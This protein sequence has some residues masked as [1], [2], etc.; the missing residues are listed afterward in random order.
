MAQSRLRSPLCPRPLPGPTPGGDTVG[1]VAVP[2]GCPI[3]PPPISPFFGQ[4]GATGLQG[5]PPWWHRV[6]GTVP[7]SG[8]KRWRGLKGP[9]CAAGSAAGTGM[10][11]GTEALPPTICHLPFIPSFL[12]LPASFCPVPPVPP[13]LPRSRPRR[14]GGGTAGDREGG[15][16]EGRT[17]RQVKG[18]SIKGGTD[19]QTEARV[20]RQR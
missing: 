8:A 9:F 6:P 10:G 3:P 13:P 15:R 18:E 2:P 12:F 14:G 20:G 17:D 16:K 5:D 19:R 7:C 1:A 11:T 4:R